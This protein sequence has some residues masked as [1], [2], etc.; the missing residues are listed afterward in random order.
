MA[1]ANATEDAARAM[2]H[3][4]T[5]TEPSHGFVAWQ[6]FGDGYVPKSSNDPAI[7]LQPILAT[8]KKCKEAKELKERF[9]AWSL[10]VAEYE[11]QFKT[12]DEA[13][14]M[15]VVREM[16]PKDIK[17]EFLT[18]PRNFDEIMEELEIIVNEM[19]ADDGP[20]PMELRNNGTHDTKTTQND[21]DTSNDMS[22]EDVCAIAWKGYKA[23]KGAGKKG[24]SESGTWHRGKGADEWPSGKRYDGGKKGGK[25]GSKP[26]WHGDKSETRYC[27]DCGEQGHIGVDCPHKLA[28][29]I[30]EEDDQTSSWESE[31]EGENAEELA[32]LETHDEEGKSEGQSHQMGEEN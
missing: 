28:N 7:A 22:Y 17:R 8:P 20:V 26:D 21:S 32:S 5:Q 10:K 27:Y 25:K 12:I 6:P 16:M 14:K 15:F 1:L 2:L 24:P 13:Q 9:T 19:M 4:I 31:P 18:Q 23:S 29:S 3:R 11:H 30:D